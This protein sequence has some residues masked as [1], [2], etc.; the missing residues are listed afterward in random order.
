MPWDNQRSSV[1]KEGPARMIHFSGNGQN[2]HLI[3]PLGLPPEKS[4]QCLLTIGLSLQS[5][6][7]TRELVSA[8]RT[9]RNI[10]RLKHRRLIGCRAGR[11]FCQVRARYLFAA[12]AIDIVDRRSSAMRPGPLKFEHFLGGQ[13]NR[14]LPPR[15]SPNIVA[16]DTQERDTQRH[17]CVGTVRQPFDDEFI[18]GELC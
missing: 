2:L 9:G 6:L 16:I 7:S 15:L 14:G 10:S 3:N 4:A 13:R 17:Q 8:T 1:S 12:T 18:S 11:S 5:L